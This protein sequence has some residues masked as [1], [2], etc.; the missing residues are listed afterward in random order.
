MR[1]LA[2][3]A[4]R[5]ACRHYFR[6]A[7]TIIII[8]EAYTA[9]IPPRLLYILIFFLQFIHLVFLS[10]RPFCHSVVIFIFGKR[11]AFDE[12]NSLKVFSRS[13]IDL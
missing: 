5:I 13:K 12:I 7:N 4:L 1:T 10:S 6:T 2:W 8:A 9:V 11:R 3:N